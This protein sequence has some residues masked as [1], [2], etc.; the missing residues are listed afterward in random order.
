MVPPL[1]LQPLV[2]N[3]IKHGLEPKVEGGRI[4]VQ[5]LEEADALVLRVRD[6]GVGLAG[7]AP[8]SGTGLGLSLVRERLATLYGGRAELHL[9]AATDAEGGTL[10]TVRLP[11][12]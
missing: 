10:V 9:Q 5:A 4:E 7:A 8:S 12:S 11:R 3:C 2:E 1:L 6:T